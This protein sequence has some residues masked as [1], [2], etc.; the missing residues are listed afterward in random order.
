MKEQGQILG[1]GS[2]PFALH[3]LKASTANNHC[4][5]ATSRK[6]VPYSITALALLHALVAQLV[7]RGTENPCVAGSTPAGGTKKGTNSNR[8][9]A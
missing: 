6:T 7:E 3:E 5:R 1:K 9:V 2:N 8:L 4:Y